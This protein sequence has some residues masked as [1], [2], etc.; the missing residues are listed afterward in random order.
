MID[1]MH[2]GQQM[3][4]TVHKIKEIGIHHSWSPMASGIMNVMLHPVMILLIVEMYFLLIMIGMLCMM[5]CL[6]QKVE[7]MSE[8]QLL[9]KQ[10]STVHV[11]S[12]P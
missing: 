1:V 10:V 7:Q 9:A 6:Y 11:V 5:K 4:S 3:V 8:A 12:K 2:D